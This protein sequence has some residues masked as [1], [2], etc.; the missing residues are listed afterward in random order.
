MLMMQPHT[1]LLL[2]LFL[3]TGGVQ[4]LLGRS[5]GSRSERL[6]SRQ[7]GPYNVTW[8]DSSVTWFTGQTY[9]VTWIAPHSGQVYIVLS[10]TSHDIEVPLAVGL[11]GYR[12]SVNITVPTNISTGGDY[13]ILLAQGNST[14]RQSFWA[15]SAPFG[16]GEAATTSAAAGLT[17]DGNSFSFSSTLGVATTPSTPTPTLPLSVSALSGSPIGSSLSGSGTTGSASSVASPPSSSASTSGDTSAARS[18][19]SAGT[20]W[21]AIFGMMFAVLGL[22]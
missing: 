4:A 18:H 6:S 13:V 11:D 8:P 22:I 21:S 14:A 12:Q 17:L 3:V 9:N 20:L 10:T 2:S 7:S 15:Q 1:F 19:Y 16:I 5:L